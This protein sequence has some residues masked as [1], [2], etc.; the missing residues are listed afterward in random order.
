MPLQ[1][2]DLI[3][4]DCE[5]WSTHV[6]KEETF[7]LK[8]TEYSQRPMTTDKT[9]PDLDYIIVDVKADWLYEYCK[10]VLIQECKGTDWHI[11]CYENKIVEIQFDFEPTPEQMQIVAEKLG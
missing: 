11:L 6:Q 7:L 4:T 5:D 10:N 9:V 8:R 3:D 2:Q 1:V